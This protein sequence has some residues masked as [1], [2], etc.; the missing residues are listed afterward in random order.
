MPFFSRILL[1]LESVRF[2][3]NSPPIWIAVTSG[4]LLP[5]NLADFHRLFSRDRHNPSENTWI[6]GKHAP[7]VEIKTQVRSHGQGWK[8]VRLGTD[9]SKGK[10]VQMDGN[11]R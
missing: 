10:Y 6:P 4:S 3:N 5:E 8:I 11:S 2:L 7:E 9:E 1:V